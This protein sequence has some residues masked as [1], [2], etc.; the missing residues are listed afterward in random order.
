MGIPLSNYGEN[1]IGAGFLGLARQLFAYFLRCWVADDQNLLSRRDAHT[2]A[3]DRPHCRH[4][5]NRH[6]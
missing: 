3:N 1:R 6:R 5:I 2:V 4:E